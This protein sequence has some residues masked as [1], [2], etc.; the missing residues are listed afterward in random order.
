MDSHTFRCPLAD[1]LTDQPAPLCS[2]LPFSHIPSH[3]TS[4]QPQ[5]EST[6]EVR[7]AS[8]KCLSPEEW[9]VLLMAGSF[10]TFSGGEIGGRKKLVILSKLM[11]V[12][13]QTHLD[14]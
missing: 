13:G 6:L 11:N 4:S 7:F 8:C 12:G 10:K 9:I 5:G 1:R 2:L 3:S 14:R